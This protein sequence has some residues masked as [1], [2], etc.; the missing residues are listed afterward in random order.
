MAREWDKGRLP[1]YQQVKGSHFGYQ[2]NEEI[3]GKKITLRFTIQQ[4]LY[5]AMNQM[6]IISR[7]RKKK[8]S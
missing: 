4:N 8:K 2:L 3:K 7:R 5:S 6:S 1:P